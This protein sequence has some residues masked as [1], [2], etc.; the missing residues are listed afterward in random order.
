MALDPGNDT[1]ASLRAAMPAQRERREALL[2]AVHAAGKQLVIELKRRRDLIAQAR[3]LR[4]EWLLLPDQALANA[5][6]ALLLAHAEQL[7]SLVDASQRFS[8][9][10]ETVNESVSGASFRPATCSLSDDHCISRPHPKGLPAISIVKP[11]FECCC[12]GIA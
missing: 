9:S 2:D 12:W 3:S 10:Q 6:E 4:K 7:E 8:D 1:V 5:V 11:S